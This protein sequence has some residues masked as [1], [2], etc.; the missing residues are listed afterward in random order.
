MRDLPPSPSDRT[1]EGHGH[2]GIDSGFDTGHVGECEASAQPP[3]S[4]PQPPLS[5]QLTSSLPHVLLPLS[6]PASILDIP[7]SGNTA[8]RSHTFTSTTSTSSA[9][10]R[11]Q[12]ALNATQFTSLASKKQCTST[13]GLN[14]TL[15][16]I[17]E[18]LNTFNTTI[19]HKLGEDRS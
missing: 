12:S 1:R 15:N 9:S 10:K 5:P 13:A 14:V 18:S 6:R 2:E 7:V 17:K 8:P 11:K 19:E 16:S 4:P 3:S